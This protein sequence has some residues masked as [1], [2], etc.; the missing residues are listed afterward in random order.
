VRVKRREEEGKLEREN[1]SELGSG[2]CRRV[3]VSERGSKRE[4]VKE[5]DCEYCLCIEKRA[6]K[7]TT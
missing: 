4:N 1:L 3:R 6:Q 2:K 5:E 7:C